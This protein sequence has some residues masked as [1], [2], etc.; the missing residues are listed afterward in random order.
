[1]SK[2]LMYHEELSKLSMEK[3]WYHE[4]LD[5]KD[6]MAWYGLGNAWSNFYI[7]NSHLN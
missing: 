6:K 4:D 1:M 5:S 2:V 3:M 7:Y